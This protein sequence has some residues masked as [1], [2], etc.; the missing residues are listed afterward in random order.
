M[1]SNG[2]RFLGNRPINVKK[3]R[4][5][6]ETEEELLNKEELAR[7]SSE[8]EDDLFP[9][10]IF[11][12]SNKSGN[13]GYLSSTP[14]KTHETSQSRLANPNNSTLSD[15]EKRLLSSWGLPDTVQRQY[16]SNGIISMFQ[17]QVECL[18]I[19]EVLEVQTVIKIFFQKITYYQFKISYVCKSLRS[20]D[21]I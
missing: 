12:D 15:E 9:S 5:K 1:A 16:A 8:N 3:V 13:S 11:D 10:C 20:V 17:W 7:K 6:S 18:S 2:T 14:T 21:N 4:K 19:G